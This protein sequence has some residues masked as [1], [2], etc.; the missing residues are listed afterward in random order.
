MNV[1]PGLALRFPTLELIR[2]FGRDTAIVILFLLTLGLVFLVDNPHNENQKLRGRIG[3]L[4]KEIKERSTHVSTL[5]SH[6]ITPL[7]IE[8]RRIRARATT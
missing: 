7:E 1:L 4:P 6:D 8:G 5:K 2:V 3:S